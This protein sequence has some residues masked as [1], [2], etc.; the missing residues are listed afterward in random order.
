MW[1]KTQKNE[2]INLDNIGKIRV[3]VMPTNGPRIYTV[4]AVTSGGET[5]LLGTY[6]TAE[7]ALEEIDSIL[8]CL[9]DGEKF[10]IMK[11]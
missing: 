1:I 7:I 6:K 3:S 9:R 11:R 5:D 2:L 10:C 4:I 8:T